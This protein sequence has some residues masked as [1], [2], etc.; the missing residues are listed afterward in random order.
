MKRIVTTNERG[1]T[2]PVSDSQFRQNFR[3]TVITT[4]YMLK[5]VLK[6]KAA[7]LYM[8]LEVFMTIVTATATVIYT[9]FPG[10]II[11]E[12]MGESRLTALCIYLGIMLVTPIL[13]SI[14]QR[15]VNAKTLNIYHRLG[16]EFLKDYDLRSAMMDYESFENPNMQNINER[17]YGTFYNALQVIDRLCSLLSAVF[18]FA[19]VFTIVARLN[20][21]IVLVV[22]L[23][24]FLN[25]IITKRQNAKDFETEK[26]K[27]PYQRYIGSS[28]ILVLHGAWAAKE[29]RLF[30]LK[31]FFAQKLYANR[32][33]VDRIS[34]DGARSS[35]NSNILFSLTGFMQQLLVYIYLIYMVIRRSLPIGSMV[36][37]MSA[38]N[39]FAG[40]INGIVKGYL[41]MARSSLEIH[42]LM[43]FM[44]SPSIQYKTGTKEP[45]FNDDSVFEFRHVSFQYP[46]SEVY[47][48]K[49]LNVSF[50]AG[51]KLC[52]VGEN[53]S[54]KTTFIKLLTRLYFPTEGEILLNGININEYDY[55]KYQSL[56][57]PVFQDFSLYLMSLRENIAFENASADDSRIFKACGE[58][59][60]DDLVEK[61]PHG[62]DTS[63]YKLFDEEG[64]EPSGGE[65]QKIAI[66]RALYSNREVYLLDEPTASLDP[67]AEYEIYTQFHNMIHGKTAIM[68]THRLSAVQLADKIAVF[69]NGQIVE[70]GT[71][72]ELY[73]N[74]GKYK[75][76]FD[77]QAEFYVNAKKMNKMIFQV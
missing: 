3:N 47:A 18:T 73:A 10:L 42:E 11:S 54:G 23:V 33:E 75:E 27:T 36:I 76:M 5:Y 64:F 37:F 17:I 16:N 31:D 74:G 60:I 57:S 46:G 25:S 52:I 43:C 71:H 53:G 21:F 34:E 58:A 12:L 24:L 56:F 4:R 65:A 39:Q 8:F 66:A 67:N 1:E 26:K 55:E 22:I 48:L 32:C 19:A 35:L 2:V 68:I 7:W 70:Y 51:Q 69:D 29:V 62:L 30:K 9:V 72:S 50:N 63:V 49:D 6:K 13:L 77:K 28:L 20:A 40:A 44:G 45:L 59:G 61:L 41:D 38:V 15:I 14:L